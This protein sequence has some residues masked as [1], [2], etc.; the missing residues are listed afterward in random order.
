MKVLVNGG[1]NLSVLDGWW[2]EAY[3]P[4]VG[5]ALGDG[6][7]HGDDPDWDAVEAEELYALLEQQVIPEFYSRNKQG[8]PT[9]W[10][11]RMRESMAQLTPQFS[12]NRTVQEYTERYYIPAAATYIERA[13]EKGKSGAQM[14]DWQHMLHHKWANLRFGDV[15][16]ETNGEWH[17]FEAQVYL[18]G[19]APDAVHVELYAD[20]SNGESQA[21]IIMSRDQQLVG[22]ENGYIY[23]GQVPMTRPS[24]DFTARIIPYFTGAAVPLEEAHI[25]WQR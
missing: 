14:V 8:I 3:T 1:I 24:G 21:K 9:A 7:E 13:T 15:T 19:I 16:V 20:K 6:S 5:W 10:V 22:A 25:L 12:A 18:N 2:A 23:K 17:I 4:E 11:A